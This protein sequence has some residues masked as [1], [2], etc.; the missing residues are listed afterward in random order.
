[1]FMISKKMIFLALNF[2]MKYKKRNTRFFGLL[3]GLLAGFIFILPPALCAQTLEVGASGGVSYY[4]GD[5]NPAIPY[6]QSKLAYGALARYN[7]NNRWAVKF[8]YTRGKLTG[9]DLKSNVVKSRDLNFKTNINDFALVTEFNFWEYFTGSK[10]NYF[11]PY[12]FGGIGF[13]TYKPFNFYG[14]DLQ[15][16]GTEGQS[17]YQDQQY[18][19][20]AP[21]KLWSISFPFGFGFKYSLTKRLGLG[22]EWGMRKTL[23]D[24]IDDISTTYYT[25]GDE[26]SD[27]TLSHTAG[28]QRG[29]EANDDWY[30]FTL[31][32]L[33]YK[34]NLY[35]S[36]KCK[37]NEW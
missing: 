4:L 8:S 9:D 23:T 18:E 3:T 37:D 15:A 12:I 32:S 16:Y 1:M 28:M 26:V 27:P 14:V 7:I 30:N 22:L 19:G 10:K 13:F 11:T 6:K 20:R 5:I 34:F 29:N 36:R 33:T 35:G 24:Y 25:S 21:Y 2:R 31:L 17:Q